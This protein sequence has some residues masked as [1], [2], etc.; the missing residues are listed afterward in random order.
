MAFVKLTRLLE[1]RTKGTFVGDLTMIG[2]TQ[3]DDIWVSTAHIVSLSGQRAE[4]EIDEDTTETR[5]VCVIM[6]QGVVDPIVVGQSVTHVMDG[7]G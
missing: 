2:Y 5:D 4:V 1:K 3:S 7:V 6:L